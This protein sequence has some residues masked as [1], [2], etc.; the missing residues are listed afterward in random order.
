MVE[1]SL[2]QNGPGIVTE[3]TSEEHRELPVGSELMIAAALGASGWWVIAHV[4]MWIAG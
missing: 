1:Q 4:V 3:I 2:R